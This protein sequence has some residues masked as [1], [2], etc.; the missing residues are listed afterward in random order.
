VQIDAAKVIVTGGA[1]FLGRHVV[2][3]LQDQGAQCI[4]PRSRDYDLTHEAAVA[5]LFAGAPADAVV[6]LAAEVGGIG[7]NRDNPGRFMFSNMI[8][9][10]LVMEYARRAGVGTY[11][12]VGTVC[13]YPKFTPVPFREESLWEGYPEETNAPYGIAKRALLVQAQA[14]RQQYGMHAMTL[15]SG[16][17]YG[18]HD[19]FD[20]HSSH[21]I[22]ALIRKMSDARDAGQGW[23]ELWGDGSASREF[24]YVE[25]AGR[26]VVLALEHYDS[27]DPV[28]LGSG[29][30]ITI[31][32]LAEIVATATG[33]DGE[34]RWDTTKPNGQPRRCLDTSRARERFG[35]TAQVPFDEGMRRTVEWFEN[36]RSAVEGSPRAAG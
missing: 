29:E 32:H 28:N 17:L 2:R 19:N 25:D 22:P 20:P 34:I 10:A 15:L 23:V 13:S 6:H 14:Y 24:L 16:N 27:P 35:F 33:F 8:M 7:A 30:E 4:V 11:L 5:R 36:E 3:L 21:V 1:G 26:A 12:Q 18:P 9:G 31:R